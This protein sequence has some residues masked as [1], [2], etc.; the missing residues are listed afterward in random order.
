MAAVCAAVLAAPHARGT[1]ALLR[2][3]VDVE[4]LKPFDGRK[5]LFFYG[6]VFV[7]MGTSAAF[8]A[9][10][11]GKEGVGSALFWIAVVCYCW[12]LGLCLLLWGCYGATKGPDSD[13]AGDV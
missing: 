2:N 5:S 8:E 10:H 7:L 13:E 12:L 3:E 4:S 9:P 1:L 11:C 6:G